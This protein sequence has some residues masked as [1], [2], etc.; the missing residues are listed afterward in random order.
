MCEK[1]K[2][3]AESRPPAI[4]LPNVSYGQLVIFN[5]TL[6]PQAFVTWAVCCPEL[7]AKVTLFMVI[8]VDVIVVGETGAPSIS[9]V[10]E[11]V[12]FVPVKVRVPAAPPQV[13]LKLNPG[14]ANVGVSITVTAVEDSHV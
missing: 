8:V 9:T 12:K 14:L 1:T 6:A 7:A 3:G 4:L 11:A 13:L 5:N 10:L 2:Q